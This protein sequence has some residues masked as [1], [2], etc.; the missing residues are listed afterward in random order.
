MAWFQTGIS[1]LLAASA[2][3]AMAQEAASAGGSIDGDQMQVGRYTTV[4]AKPAEE[5]SQPLL[6]MAR[7]HFP[8]QTVRTVGEA[9]RHTLLRTGWQ[10]ASGGL[11]PDARRVL[12]LP[13]PESQRVLGPYRV[14]TILDVLLGSSWQ[15]H[16]DP[17][18]RTVWFTLTQGQP[19]QLAPA[20]PTVQSQARHADDASGLSA[21]NA[22]QEEQ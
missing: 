8:R 18:R 16:E 9:V 11:S 1:A 2:A 17:V 22:V 13:L 21:A 19:S 12:D 10:L 20:M 14:R 4:R 15:W 6:V 5:A 7:I 3:A